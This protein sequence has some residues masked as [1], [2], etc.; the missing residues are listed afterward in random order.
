M[1]W[2]QESGGSGQ[3][4]TVIPAD[5][6]DEG[7]ATTPRAVSAERLAALKDAAVQAAAGGIDF[8][9][10]DAS[11]FIPRTTSGCGIDSVETAT[12]RI[13]RDLL[14]FDPGTLDGGAFG[15]QRWRRAR[16][17]VRHCAERDRWLGECLHGEGIGGDLGHHPR[18]HGW[19]EE[20]G[21]VADFPGCRQRG[22]HAGGRCGVGWGFI[23]QGVMSRRQRHLNARHAGANVVLD[24]RYAPS[25][26]VETWLDRS[27]NSNNATQSEPDRR[28]TAM[29][30][31][32]RSFV[33]FDGVDDRMAT[34]PLNQ[35]QPWSVVA[36]TY[37][38]RLSSGFFSFADGSNGNA[39]LIGSSRLQLFAGS[40]L[41]HATT[42]LVNQWYLCSG[43]ANGANSVVVLNGAGRIAGNPGAGAL[44]GALRL[45]ANW[46]LAIHQDND[47]AAVTVFPFALSDS[48]R[49][50]IEQSIALS[51]KIPT[52]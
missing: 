16:F 39:L 22:R 29:T 31:G 8:I 40:A 10:F 46:N 15:R 24:A 26:A 2:V 33:R 32:G 7:T 37:P 12:N 34:P 25:G 17:C 44:G 38:R 43:V 1:G 19:R 14:L 21:G 30:E 27:S 50:R 3:S 6:M 11:E 45:G 41:N 9:A 52:S 18:R 28:P 4:L 35:A 23:A 5:E 48:L 51:F 47:T 20:A 49:R 13:N 42:I 36:L